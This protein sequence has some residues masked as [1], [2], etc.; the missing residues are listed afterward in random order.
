MKIAVIIPAYNSEDTIKKVINSVK[1]NISDGYI[2]VVDD[3]SSDQTSSISRSSG[4]IVLSH[5]DNLGKGAALKTGFQYALD[6]NVDVVATLDSDGQHSP[7]MLNEFLCTMRNEKVDFVIGTRMRALKTMPFHRML[8]NKITSGLISLR[9]GQFIEDSQCGYRLIRA[10]ILQHLALQCQYFDLESE[11][12]LK[13]GLSGC[14]FRAVP[15]ETIYQ[16]SSSSIHL[17]KDTLRFIKLYF[18]SYF[19]Y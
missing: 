15:I 6:L 9:I 12:I 2:I 17:M 3:G 7:D 10:S 1:N 4:V 16:N 19:W 5:Q 14:R 8:S 13:A 18:R 11:I